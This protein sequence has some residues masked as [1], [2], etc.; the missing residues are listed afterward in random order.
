MPTYICT[1]TYTDIYIATHIHTYTD[2]YIHTYTHKFS[3]IE[4]FCIQREREGERE[5]AR[6]RERER[7]NGM[8]WYQAKIN[9]SKSDLQ[10]FPQYIIFFVFKVSQT[11]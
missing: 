3:Y 1:H 6:E 9:K 7:E 2:T 5:R 11:M 10:T 8:E 4:T